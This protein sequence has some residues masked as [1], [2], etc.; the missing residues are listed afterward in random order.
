MSMPTGTNTTWAQV[1][2]LRRA[3]PGIGAGR[4]A[5]RLGICRSLAQR[6]LRETM[7]EANERGRCTRK[8]RHPTEMHARAAIVAIRA[9]GNPSQLS[10]YSCSFCGGWHVGHT[11]GQKLMQILMA[12]E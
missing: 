2:E 6:L 3:E 8:R 4:I 10:A 11:A 9:E 12:A 5:R 7:E 1:H